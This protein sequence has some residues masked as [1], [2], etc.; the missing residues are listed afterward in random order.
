M[1]EDALKVLF[2]DKY[3]LFIKRYNKESLDNG[4]SEDRCT[5][6]GSKITVNVTYHQMFQ[7]IRLFHL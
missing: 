2:I 5:K 6:D 4:W 1:L 7:I 3:F